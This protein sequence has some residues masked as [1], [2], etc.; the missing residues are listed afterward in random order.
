M[1]R[2]RSLLALCCLCGCRFV[3]MFEPL[4]RVYSQPVLAGQQ[5]FLNQYTAEDGMD[6]Y[7]PVYDTAEGQNSGLIGLSIVRN[8][9]TESMAHEPSSH[10]LRPIPYIR[11]A[12]SFDTNN[13][14]VKELEAPVMVMDGAQA[15]MTIRGSY[16][17]C[18]SPSF[19]TRITLEADCRDPGKHPFAQSGCLCVGS[20]S[21]VVGFVACLTRCLFGCLRGLLD[22]LVVYV[23]DVLIKLRVVKFVS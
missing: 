6:R 9:W 5:S 7:R 8:F 22:S 17:R 18:P 12:F 1:S 19:W 10:G 11:L 20:S 2:R 14:I 23:G 21:C 3:A 16:G 4:R 15:P 13:S